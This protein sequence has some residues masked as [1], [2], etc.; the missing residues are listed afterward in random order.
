[1]GG[2]ERG[3]SRGGGEGEGNSPFFLVSCVPVAFALSTSLFV[4]VCVRD[5]YTMFGAHIKCCMEVNGEAHLTKKPLF[6]F[7]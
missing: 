3:N 2:E 6:F 5:V 4:C 7:E 1:M